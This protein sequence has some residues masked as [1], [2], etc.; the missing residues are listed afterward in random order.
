MKVALVHEF[1]TQYGGAERVLDNF[2][3]IFPE[4][5]LHT[6]VHDEKI[7]IRPQNIK[8]GFLNFLA[9]FVPYKWLL[10]LMPRAVESFDLSGYD[11]VLSDSSAFAKGVKTPALHISYCHTPTRYIWESRDEYLS[12]LRLPKFIKTL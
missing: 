7:K 9:K 5:V 8:T 4:A 2:S 3:E 6:L 10:P 1:V 12:N 11:L